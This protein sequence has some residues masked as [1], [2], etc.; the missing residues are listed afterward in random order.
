[1]PN[2]KKPRKTKKA[3]GKGITDFIKKAYK[4]GEN[5]YNK[6]TE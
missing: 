1:M 5:L 6:A 4:T 3:N 2:Y